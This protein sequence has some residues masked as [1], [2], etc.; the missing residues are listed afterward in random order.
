M[1]TKLERLLALAGNGSSGNVGT[2]SGSATALTSVIDPALGDGSGS[3][4]G[5]GSGP[6]ADQ[7]RNGPVVN[8]LD[9]GENS[10]PVASGSG[11]QPSSNEEDHIVGSAQ[12]STVEVDLG[13]GMA[14]DL[15]LS[16]RQVGRDAEGT[17]DPED[18]VVNGN[19]DLGPDPSPTVPSTDQQEGQVAPKTG[20]E[21]EL[22]LDMTRLRVLQEELEGLR[23]R[24]AARSA[25]QSAEGVDTALVSNDNLAGVREQGTGDEDDADERT[26]LLAHVR[27]LK[28]ENERV[29]RQRKTLER[30]IEK[31]KI[32][33]ASRTRDS[34]EDGPATSTE[35]EDGV[36]VERALLEVRGWLDDA[37]KTWSA[38]SLCYKLSRFTRC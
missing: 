28:E 37:L 8:T 17:E 9:T 36:G 23:R 22:G 27:F 30:E 32:L 29:G 15:D 10:Q 1:R 21:G 18:M 2:G 31:R 4:S 24:L 14:V 35:L 12:E 6:G 5:S 20:V 38:V 11:T 34:D 13:Q 26:A 16:G 25:S 3:G 19:N 33:L 7:T